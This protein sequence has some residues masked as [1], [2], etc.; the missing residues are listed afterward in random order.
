MN[1]TKNIY[2]FIIASLLFVIIAC[3]KIDDFGEVTPE[4]PDYKPGKGV[5][6]INEGNFG[7][8]N[9]SISF[10]ND[11]E[12]EVYND[13]FFHATDRP[14]GDVPLSMTN[15]GDSGWIVVNNS[16]KI[17]VVD[18]YDMS[19]LATISGLSSPRFVVPVSPDRVY[20]SDFVESKISII[21]TLDFSLE[22][23]IELGCSSEQMLLANGKVF[24]A[25]WSNYGFSHLENN[26]LK[27][28]DINTDQVVDSVE[29]GKE[30]N[31][32]VL[33]K[34][35]KLWVLCSGGFGSEEK[36]SLCCIDTENLE[37]ISCLKF[38]D[39][40]SSPTSLCIN[41]AG[42]MLF[43]LNKGV[44]KFAITAQE[45]PVLPLIPEG[46]HLFYSLA[47]DPLTTE[48]F[49]TDAIDYQ[50]RGL[51]LKYKPEGTFIGSF[52]AGVIPGM[53]VFR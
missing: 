27:I 39:I 41:G 16:G 53:M 37:I 11:D 46:E 12:S 36:P 50:Q 30:P 29:V 5:F 4:G 32:M 24:V 7:N 25:F 48:I 21:N 49:A 28:I 6:V 3:D 51:V 19:S 14:L 23:K 45:L 43:F 13:I 1:K 17:E 18:L 38:P 33:D 2:L 22:G 42:D 26:Q 8:G 40:N 34:E 35:G 47:I 15:M 9:G 44:F 31:S 10:I 52:R 20:V